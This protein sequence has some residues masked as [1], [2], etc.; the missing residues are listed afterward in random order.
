MKTASV[1]RNS[2]N[3]GVT[4]ALETLRVEAT[5][6]LISRDSDKQNR[7]DDGELKL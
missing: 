7:T 3:G 5:D 4:R 1:M 2:V 6:Q